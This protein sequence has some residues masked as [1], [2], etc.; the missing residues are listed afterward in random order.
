MAVDL[1]QPLWIVATT[2]RGRLAVLGGTN[3]EL[4]ART[5]AG[6]IHEAVLLRAEPAR[7]PNDVD[8]TTPA[9]RAIVAEVMARREDGE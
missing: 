5:L 8:L 7:V 1:T 6:V 4:E 9:G 2:Q 3:D